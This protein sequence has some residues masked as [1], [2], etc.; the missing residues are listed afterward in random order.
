M[1]YICGS[2]SNVSKSH[3]HAKRQKAKFWE[4]FEPSHTYA[5]LVNANHFIANT[6]LMFSI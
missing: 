2:P 5:T 3:M 4:G 6:T 1:A